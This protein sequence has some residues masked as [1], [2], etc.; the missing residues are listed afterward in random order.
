M[1]GSDRDELRNFTPATELPFAGHPLVEGV[2]RQPGSGRLP[3]IPL[4]SLFPRT[5]TPSQRT[6]GLFG[7]GHSVGRKG[8]DNAT[9]DEEGKV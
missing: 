9:R 2:R 7:A 4:V 1:D 8:F 6:R 3:L 5:P